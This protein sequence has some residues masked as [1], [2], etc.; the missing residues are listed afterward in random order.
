LGVSN[1]GKNN[2]SIP[3]IPKS[4]T[5]SGDMSP[6]NLHPTTYVSTHTNNQLYLCSK[7]TD[8]RKYKIIHREYEKKAASEQF[9]N[10]YT[11][12]QKCYAKM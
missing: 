7:K 1:G 5:S 6:Q 3:A 11:M 12:P 2:V 8:T 4:D 10:G 9:L